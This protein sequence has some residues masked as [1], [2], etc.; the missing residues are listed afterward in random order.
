M[1]FKS[2]ETVIIS[3]N[4]SH[5]VGVVLNQYVINK[6]TM[7]DVLL[8]SRSAVTMIGTSSSKNMYINKSLTEKLCDT[9]IITTTIPYKDL[10]ET[11][12]LPICNS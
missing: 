8:E 1:S 3:N 6:K 5:Q 2:G 9:G 11:D 12:S 4:D 10:L 7:Y